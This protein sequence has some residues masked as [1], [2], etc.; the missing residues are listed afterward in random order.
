MVAACGSISTRTRN[1]GAWTNRS[2]NGAKNT[3]RRE[4]V[5]MMEDDAMRACVVNISETSVSEGR[6]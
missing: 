3:R 1:H 4:R 2:R 6:A 5:C